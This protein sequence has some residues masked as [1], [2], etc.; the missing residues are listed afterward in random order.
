[1]CLSTTGCALLYCWNLLRGLQHLM[2]LGFIQPWGKHASSSLGFHVSTQSQS[3]D[4]RLVTEYRTGPKQITSVNGH[5]WETETVLSI[6]EQE[7]FI[8]VISWTWS[9]N[10]FNLRCVK[11][12]AAGVTCINTPGWDSDRSNKVILLGGCNV[13]PTRFLTQE[14]MQV[15]TYHP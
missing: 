15:Q 7:S 13:S 3:W 9:T 11:A 10:T 5:R 8:I 12:V 1:M 14:S 2:G 4:S 6:K